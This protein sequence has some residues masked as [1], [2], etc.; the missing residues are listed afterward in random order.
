MGFQ[1]DVN[2]AAKAVAVSSSSEIRSRLQSYL[3]SRG[4]FGRARGLTAG[5]TSSSAKLLRRPWRKVGQHAI[6]AGALEGDEA[7]HHRLVAVDPA[8]VGSIGSSLAR[9]RKRLKTV[10]KPTPA[11]IATRIADMN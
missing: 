11:V 2:H 9:S 1:F 4:E 3:A 5:E 6:R 8:C 10:S 7:L